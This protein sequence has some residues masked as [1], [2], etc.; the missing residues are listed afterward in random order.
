M[1]SRNGII[2]SSFEF[3]MRRI[4][5]NIKKA[6]IKSGAFDASRRPH[7]RCIIPQFRSRRV[8]F[9]S[10]FLILSILHPSWT[11][12]V[13][14]WQPR[15]SEIKANLSAIYSVT[16]N[17]H[18]NVYRAHFDLEKSAIFLIGYKSRLGETKNLRDS[19]LNHYNS[20]FFFK[21]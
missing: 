11:R 5:S 9:P 1:G 8:I 18:S 2:S 12:V 3:R 4:T 13:D 15:K 14:L 19:Y 20:P 16:H 6:K 17:P 10:L 21:V 7:L